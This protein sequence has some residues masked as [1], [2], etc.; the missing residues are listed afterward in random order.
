MSEEKLYP[1]LKDLLRMVYR[2]N[3]S[4]N[5]GC[6]LF[7]FVGYKKDPEH[8]CIDCGDSCDIYDE[9]KSLVGAYGDKETLRSMLN[10]LR[11][12]I[13]DMADEEGFVTF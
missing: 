11:D 9:E 5:D 7:R 12:L 6:F 8:K 10:E 4:H 1:E 13:E 3:T 2:Y